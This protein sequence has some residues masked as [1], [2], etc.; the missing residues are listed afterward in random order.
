M[1]LLLASALKVI[2]LSDK[3][4]YS[5]FHHFFLQCVHMAEIHQKVRYT[6]TSLCAPHC[7]NIKNIKLYSSRSRMGVSQQLANGQKVKI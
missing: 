7:T 4:S 6:I 5:T 1:T 3:K 2:V